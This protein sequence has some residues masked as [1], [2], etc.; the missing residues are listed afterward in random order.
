MVRNPRPAHAR[1]TRGPRSSTDGT[2]AQHAGWRAW[3]LYASLPSLEAA[4]PG[5]AR[6]GVLLAK[7]IR[8]ALPDIN[9]IGQSCWLYDCLKVLRLAGTALATGMAP[10]PGICWTSTFRPRERRT[11]WPCSATAASGQ[12]VLAGAWLTRPNTLARACSAFHSKIN[13][14]VQE[15]KCSVSAAGH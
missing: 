2:V 7:N 4:T 10:E 9:L 12:Q 3:R 1:S 15:G 13:T 8:H 14:N 6:H 11:L 5:P